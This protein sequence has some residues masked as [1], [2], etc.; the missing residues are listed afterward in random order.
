LKSGAGPARKKK[1]ASKKAALAPVDNAPLDAGSLVWSAIWAWIKGF[2]AR[3]F[4]KK[5]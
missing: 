3:L 2:F 4:G 5:Q 1:P